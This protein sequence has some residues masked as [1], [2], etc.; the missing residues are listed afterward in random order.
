MRVLKHGGMA[1]ACAVSVALSSLMLFLCSAWLLSS[2][3]LVQS[4]ALTAMSVLGSG[5]VALVELHCRNTIDPAVPRVHPHRSAALFFESDYLTYCSAP[6]GCD[7]A[8][9]P[10]A[11]GFE[12]DRVI[13]VRSV[14][15]DDD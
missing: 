12:R 8:E 13:Q 4:L 10:I 2:A 11:K 3:S 6:S 1:V 14:W 5:V 7:E 15:C 9:A